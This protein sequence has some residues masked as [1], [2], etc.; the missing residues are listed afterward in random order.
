MCGKFLLDIIVA[1]EDRN[2]SKTDP[3]NGLWMSSVSNVISRSEGIC[4]VCMFYKC[5]VLQMNNVDSKILLIDLRINFNFYVF[6][7]YHFSKLILEI[8]G[9]S[10]TTIKDGRLYVLSNGIISLIQSQPKTCSLQVWDIV[11]DW[12]VL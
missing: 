10:S 12:V 3:W 7:E 6:L 5:S 8:Q 9:F 1:L 2:C 4:W 11:L